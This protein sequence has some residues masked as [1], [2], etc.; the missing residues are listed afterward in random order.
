MGFFPK[1]KILG[2]DQGNEKPLDGIPQM[3]G[4]NDSILSGWCYCRDAPV[5]IE[6]V[7]QERQV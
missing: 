4:L 7:S 2:E 6:T 1:I 5:A 3:S